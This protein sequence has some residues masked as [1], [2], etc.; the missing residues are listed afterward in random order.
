M[1][2]RLSVHVVRIGADG[3]IQIGSVLP[4]EDTFV[5]LQSAGGGFHCAINYSRRCR[6]FTWAVQVP[7]SP[8]G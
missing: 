6:Q 3:K 8:D 1:F 7:R 4:E 2:C 5:A